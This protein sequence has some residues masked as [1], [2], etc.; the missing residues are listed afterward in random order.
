MNSVMYE[1]IIQGSIGS[2]QLPINSHMFSIDESLEYLILEFEASRNAWFGLLVWDPN[3]VLRIQY[4]QGRSPNTLVLHAK[5][6]L[7][8][9]LTVA[10]EIVQGEWKVEVMG[11]APVVTKLG[12]ITYQLHIRGGRGELDQE[13]KYLPIDGES[14][15]QIEN[16]HFTLERYSWDKPV[17]QTAGWY[18]G[19]FH[20]HTIL[21]DGKMTPKENLTQAERQGL[22]FF[23]A[24]DH[25]VLST[26]WEAG[27][28]LVIPG[29]EITS[30]KGHFNALG[31]REWIDWRF[32]EPDGG[33]ITEAG[34]NRVL[35][36]TK[37]KGGLRSI[38]HPQLHP[39]HWAFQETKLSEIDVLEIWNDP[40][41]PDNR[42]ATEEAL[43]L[44]NTLWNDGYQ[45]WGIG[46][47]DSHMRPDESYGEDGI[48][49]LIGDPATYV[50]VECLSATAILHSVSKG[51][52]YVSRK[53]VL[54]MEIRIG[55]ERYSVGEDLTDLFQNTE[56]SNDPVIFSITYSQSEN[57]YILYW[58][59]NGERKHE[60]LL[61]EEG[62][63]EIPLRWDGLD[64]CWGRV[65]IRS[66]EGELQAF[67]N[68]VYCGK[69]DQTLQTWNDLLEKSGC[70]RFE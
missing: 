56:E 8:S 37:R 38:N 67:S 59:E 42:K 25:H 9:Y 4:L 11:A 15:T 68:P 41:F 66:Q 20:T 65:E 51:R 17:R 62:S 26:G 45:I 1:S 21:S 36:E 55:S 14:W 61:R 6:H 2:D 48:P 39:W 12:S 5:P 3:G 28:I 13:L 18:K 35:Q 69:K 54:D 16:H 46:G 7:T 31:P 64:Y 34:M 57:D 50:Y 43:I 27:E 29:V 44:W 63:I 58:I 60:I 47:S 23:V 52:V 70:E 22:D 30:P 49:S 33:M 19:D 53:P 32:T 10:G 40:T 24:T